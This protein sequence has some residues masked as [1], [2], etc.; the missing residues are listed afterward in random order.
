[1]KLSRFF[2]GVSL[3]AGSLAAACSSSSGGGENDNDSGGAPHDGGGRSDGTSDA[4]A[5]D[6]SREA[7]GDAGTSGH[8][9]SFDTGSDSMKADTGHES[10]TEAGPDAGPS[11]LGT[12]LVNGSDLTVFGVTTD[13]YVIYGDTTTLWA[14]PVAG[15]SATMLASG[16]ADWAAGVS[17]QVAFVFQSIVNNVGTLSIWSHASGFHAAS[18]SSWANF[19]GF[20]ASSDGSRVLFLANVHV[21]DGGTLTQSDIDIANTDLTD[22]QT[23]AANVN[24][25]LDQCSPSLAFPG[26]SSTLAVVESCPLGS[27]MGTAQ[28]FTLSGTTWTGTNLSTALGPNGFV[29][30]S[31]G[32]QLMAV[33][34]TGPMLS[35]D[36]NSG[37]TTTL[38][39]N[40]WV[41]GFYTS[42]GTNAVFTEASLLVDAAVDTNIVTTP[43]SSPS[44]SVIAAHGQRAW[45]PSPNESWFT[46]TYGF[47]ATG[48][49]DL[50][51]GSTAGTTTA[52]LSLSSTALPGSFTAD[53]N[54]V[55][56]D[57]G[58]DASTLVGTL[59]AQAVSSASP[60]V[61]ATNSYADFSVV[62]ATG[63]KIVYNSRYAAPASGSPTADLY[64]VDLASGSPTLVASGATAYIAPAS[65][66]SAVAYSIGNR[67]SAL[68]GVWVY[69][70]P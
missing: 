68:D 19:D 61:V 64:W 50:Y 66:S 10:G 60:T 47:A 30:D 7:T 44:P 45:A 2:V 21:A 9:A 52:T 4:M 20:A 27:E 58:I 59:H 34:Y 12:L 11:P 14:V 63:S 3:L 46:F 51:L 8:E 38:T 18:S 48:L 23:L 29:I 15:G 69:A 33:S 36:I 57:D 26:T 53:S 28:R 35:I 56:W 70:V 22:Q 37:T 17:G 39:T 16:L 6:A 41:Q 25:N 1:M 43:V 31:T 49:V 5:S 54:Y 55:V 67:S 62:G 32:T 42:S 65:G 24:L 40:G 13:D